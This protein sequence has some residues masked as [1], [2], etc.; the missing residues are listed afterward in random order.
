MTRLKLALSVI[1]VGAILALWWLVPLI[2]GSILAGVILAGGFK[3][4]SIR[5]G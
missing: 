3:N 1:V 5:N 2:L 4:D